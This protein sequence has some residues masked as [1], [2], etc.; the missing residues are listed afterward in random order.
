MKLFCLQENLKNILNITDRSTSYNSTLPILSNIL[1]IAD[2]N[3]LK[4]LATNLEIGITASIPAKIDKKGEVC[5]GSKLINSFIDGVGNGKI[6]IELNNNSLNIKKDDYNANLPIL[7]TKNFPIIPEIKSGKEIKLKQK[8]IKKCL[9]AVINSTAISDLKPELTG[10]YFNIKKDGIKSAA[11]DSFRLSEKISS[12]NN[13]NLNNESFILPIKTSQELIRLLKDDDSE[14]ILNIDK[15]QVVFEFDNIKISSKLI[16]GQYPNYEQI[17]PKNFKTTII[18]NK[19][20]FLN[21]L[22]VASVFCGKNNDIK[23]NVNKNGVEITSKDSE[24]GENVN[25]IQG[26][27]NGPELEIVFNYKYLID[28]LNNIK[29]DEIILSFNEKN[30]PALLTDLKDK[31]YTYL[32]MPIKSI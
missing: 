4:V 12:F 16:D 26:K 15:N 21:N 25:K 17:I 27:I 30:T 29:N 22:K 13:N 24:K 32:I 19:Q 28:G 31:N 20:E 11:T 23:L 18:I 6:D 3:Q 1:L 5:V 10:I 7:D 8:D 9:S 14:I 2:N